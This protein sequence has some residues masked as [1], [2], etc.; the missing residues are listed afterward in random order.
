MLESNYGLESP[1]V[2]SPPFKDERPVK[3]TEDPDWGAYWQQPHYA[4]TDPKPQL[5]D[6]D[7]DIEEG[8]AGWRPSIF[9]PRWA[10]RITLEIVSVRAERVQDISENDAEAEGIELWQEVFFREYNKP[11]NNPGWTRDPRLSFQTLWDSINAKRGYG[12][13][14]NPWVWVIEFKKL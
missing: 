13:D 9:M 12:W 10:S 1:S 3:W 5:V 2:Y 11:D 6:E 4:A 7:R 14:V 8:L